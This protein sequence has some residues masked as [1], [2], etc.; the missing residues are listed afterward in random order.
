MGIENGLFGD[1]QISVSSIM[2]D[3]PFY[4][5]DNARLNTKPIPYV[6][7]G[8]W[9]AKNL[10][11]QYIRVRNIHKLRVCKFLEVCYEQNRYGNF[12]LIKALRHLRFVASDSDNIVKII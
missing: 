2:G 6:S 12:W 3:M 4:S 7:A 1:D 11:E 5:K 10:P 8:A 9:A